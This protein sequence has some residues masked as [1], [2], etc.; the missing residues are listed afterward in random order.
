[1]TSVS[2]TNR[3]RINYTYDAAGNLLTVTTPDTVAPTVYSTDPANGAID[4]PVDKTVY[5]TF[6]ENIQPG[7]NYAG[8]ALKIGGTVVNTTYSIAGKVLTINPVVS[9]NHSTA[10]AVYIPA[11]SVKDTAGNPLAADYVFTFTT[12]A[13]LDTIPPEVTVTYPTDGSTFDEGVSVT[14]TAYATDNVG[15]TK[16]QFF[17]DGL[18]IGEDTTEPY[19]CAWVTTA[20]D[21]SV[22]AKAYDAAE[23]VGTSQAVNVHVAAAQSF[24]WSQTFQADFD[25]GQKENVDTNT[26]PGDVL[27]TSG[28]DFNQRTIATGLR[29]TLAIK[30]DGAVAAVGDNFSGQCDIS[31]WSI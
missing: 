9:L 29:H 31:N 27:L 4:V 3:Q 13:T 2:Y 12:Q 11:G 25:A 5:V 21:H 30:H 16:V 19:S 1:L 10:Y 14:I 18:L 24:E 28:A 20:G 7:P 17:I 23:N 22:V 15:V 26:S 6:S 8:I